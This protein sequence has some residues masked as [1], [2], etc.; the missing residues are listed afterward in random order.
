MLLS[1]DTLRLQL[2]SAQ[3]LCYCQTMKQPEMANKKREVP[4]KRL[5]NVH[6]DVMIVWVGGVLKACKC[7][8]DWWFGWGC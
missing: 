1:S 7:G 8:I 4:V 6:M 2:P 3:Q 5:P